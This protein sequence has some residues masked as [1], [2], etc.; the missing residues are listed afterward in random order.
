MERHTTTESVTQNSSCRLMPSFSCSGDRF[1][2]LVG[3]PTCQVLLGFNHH[4]PTRYRALLQPHA[5]HQSFFFCCDRDSAMCLHPQG[6]AT[7]APPHN[8]QLHR[9]PG[10]TAA[11]PPPT[12]AA[13]SSHGY[14][15]VPSYL[16]ALGIQSTIR[17]LFLT[18]Q[19]TT[20]VQS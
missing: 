16:W 4:G 3:T 9:H 11:T 8:Q 18:Y 2:F 15:V 17:T 10:T 1:L 7:G 12:P 13:K 19:I 20:Q 14:T 6:M 5:S